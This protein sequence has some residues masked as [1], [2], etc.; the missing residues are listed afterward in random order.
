MY[1][2]LVLLM[3]LRLS[4]T[5]HDQAITVI[6][7]SSTTITVNVGISSDTTT[8]NWAGGTSVAAVQSGG[9][10]NHIFVST[11]AVKTGGDYNHTF[12]GAT[13][14]AVTTTS[15][16]I[17][18]RTNPTACSDV[19]SAIDTLGTIITDAL[20]AGNIT[21]GIW[22]VAANTG[23]FITGE[24]KC[25]R[26]L[27]IV[28]DAVAQDLWFGGNEFSIAATKEHFNGNQLLANGIDATKE[29]QP[30]ITAFKRAEEL[31]QRALNNPYYDRD[32]NI[33]LDTVGDPPLFGDIECD[34]HD[35]V[36]ANQVF[37][38][39]EAY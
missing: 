20:T 35:M 32:L 2:C 4:V 29:V 31:M 11:G 37:I 22:N 1:L 16:T 21:G 24:A 8:H 7:T 36:L 19:Q 23:T 12:V 9:S 14:G 26:D 6:G 38:A 27:G 39:K 34:A 18:P 28:V 25:R 10:Y 33:T 3:V 15:S 5:E 17:E 30:A 13:V